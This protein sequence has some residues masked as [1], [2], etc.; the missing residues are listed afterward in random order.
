MSNFLG[1]NYVRLNMQVGLSD[2]SE[3]SYRNEVKISTQTK[4][5]GISWQRHTIRAGF[6][7]ISPLRYDMTTR[8]L[9]TNLLS[10][11]KSFL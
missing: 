8:F 10:E 11:A 3:L 9:G 6:V 2:K 4:F 7:W 5:P 1:N